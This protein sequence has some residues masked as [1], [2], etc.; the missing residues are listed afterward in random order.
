MA[1]A[2]RCVIGKDRRAG[3]AEHLRVLEEFFNVLVRIAKLAAVAFIKDEDELLV[4]QVRDLAQIMLFHN[5]II[6]LLDCGQDQL[7]A[8][9]IELLDQLSNPRCGSLNN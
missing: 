9:V 1:D 6:E 4:L 3:K 5:R 8:V 2:A 7:G